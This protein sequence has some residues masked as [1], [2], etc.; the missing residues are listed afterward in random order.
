M[1]NPPNFPIVGLLHEARRGVPREARRSVSSL[2]PF[3]VA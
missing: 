1:F 3:F 2:A